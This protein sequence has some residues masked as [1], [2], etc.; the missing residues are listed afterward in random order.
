MGTATGHPK[1]QKRPFEVT[2]RNSADQTRT[3]TVEAQTE[4]DAVLR[5][6]MTLAYRFVK[7]DN[8][9]NWIVVKV[10]DPAPHVVIF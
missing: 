3:T 6:G 2:L 4:H 8:P 9:E 5:A 7:R 1:H 10:H